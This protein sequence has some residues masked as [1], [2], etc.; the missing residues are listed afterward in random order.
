MN[1]NIS[2]NNTVEE[3]LRIMLVEKNNECNLLRK[4]IEVLR[5]TVAEEQEGKYRA[6]IKF[7]DLQKEFETLK[8]K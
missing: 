5:H 4:Q 1:Q 3:E 6:Y 7:A 2:L 8:K